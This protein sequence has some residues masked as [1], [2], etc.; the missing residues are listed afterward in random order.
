MLR[1]QV[2]FRV[3]QDPIDWHGVARFAVLVF[4]LVYAGGLLI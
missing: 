2:R 4:G 1:N 3:Y